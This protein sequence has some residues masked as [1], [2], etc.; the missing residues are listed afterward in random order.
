M[1]DNKNNKILEDAAMSDEELDGVAGGTLGQMQD[2]FSAIVEVES[3]SSV[4][5]YMMNGAACVIP[6]V[7]E[8]NKSVVKKNL[9][10]IGID[11]KIDIGW[12]GWGIC[13]EDNVYTDKKTGKS[14]SHEEVL[15]RIK[16]DL[17][18]WI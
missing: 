13:S 3:G 9:S 2:L 15:S 18:Y 17:P 12:L 10:L 6:G 4:L 14:L 5:G 1:K 8:I 16:R 11:A 7:N